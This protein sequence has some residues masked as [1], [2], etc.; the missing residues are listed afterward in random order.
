VIDRDPIPGTATLT[1]AMTA[2]NEDGSGIS[3]E[4]SSSV[5]QGE[6]KGE[7]TGGH[8]HN[9]GVRGRSPRSGRGIR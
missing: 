7:D 2:R 5:A 9:A 4:P 8:Q 3:D 6:D 1:V